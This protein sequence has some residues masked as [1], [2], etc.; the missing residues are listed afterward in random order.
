MFVVAIPDPAF[1]ECLM[2]FYRRNEHH[3]RFYVPKPEYPHR[4]LLKEIGDTLLPVCFT[5]EHVAHQIAKLLGNGQLT[6]LARPARTNERR[7]GFPADIH[8]GDM[9]D[10]PA[11]W[12]HPQMIP[13]PPHRPR[14]DG[15][16]ARVNKTLRAKQDTWDRIEAEAKRKDIGTGQVLDQLAGTLPPAVPYRTRLLNLKIAKECSQCGRPHWESTLACNVPVGHT[17]DESE[18]EA[19]RILCWLLTADEAQLDQTLAATQP[20]LRK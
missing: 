8:A 3:G 12:S 10:A 15:G 6:V 7:M 1:P 20:L 5:Q 18:A 9:L 14:L 19:K 4:M 17:K 11:I 16:M 13:N 2:S